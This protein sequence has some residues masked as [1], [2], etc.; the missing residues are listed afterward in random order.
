MDQKETTLV[1]L[2][3]PSGLELLDSVINGYKAYQVLSAALELQLF[4]WLNQSGGS[5]REEIITGIKINGGPSRGF[6]QSLVNMGFLTCRDEKYFNSEVSTKFLVRHSQYYQGDYLKVIAAQNAK[7]HNLKTLLVES[8]PAQC[9]FNATSGE[10]FIK[11][12]AQRSLRGELQEVTRAVVSWEKFS[13]A[14]ALLDIGGD[15]GLYAIAL[16]QVNP[17]LRAVVFDKPHF[18]EFTREFVNSYGLKDRVIVR[19]DDDLQAE[20]GTGYDIVLIS[21][22]IYRFRKD[23]PFVFRK[24]HSCLKPGGLLM[25]NHW[26]CGPGCASSAVDMRELDK[27]LHSFGHPLCHI[28]AFND[29]LAKMGFNVLQVKDICSAYGD[30]KLHLAVKN[31]S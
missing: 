14:K 16:C 13:G 29:Q 18:I 20:L 9:K 25:L 19:G 5:T 2:N 10:D 24:M 4:E 22:L 15:H 17:E 23:I 21:H 27:S 6:L 30:S 12:L 3:V 11:A 1:N 31:Q 7:W 28:E 8:E 26:F